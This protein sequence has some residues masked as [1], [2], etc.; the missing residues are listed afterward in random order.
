MRR[1]IQL[2]IIRMHFGNNCG[3][4]RPRQ[5]GLERSR[6][7]YGMH[8]AL[9]VGKRSSAS[10][11]FIAGY[12]EF[13]LVNL[14]RPLLSI[15]YPHRPMLP[16]AWRTRAVTIYLASPERSSIEPAFA[17]PIQNQFPGPRPISSPEILQAE[18]V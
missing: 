2:R 18:P 5:T 16:H 4:Y 7:G 9:L 3:I 14:P 12:L 10:K 8:D 11:S 13:E 17:Y 1:Q 6:N 15:P